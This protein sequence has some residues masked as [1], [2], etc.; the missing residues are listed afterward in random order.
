MDERQQY[1]LGELIMKSLSGTADES[2]FAQMRQCLTNDPEAL[3][4]YFEYVG[5]YAYLESPGNVSFPQPEVSFDLQTWQLLSEY[6]KT[7]PPAEIVPEKPR[8]KEPVKM[9]KVEKPPRTIHKFSLYS[10]II[11]TAA[12]FFAIM[13]VQLAPVKTTPLVGKLTRTVAAQWQDASGHITQGCDLYAGPMS[14][15]AGFA[16]IT[17]DSGAIIVVQA[18]S[19]FTLESAQQVY[20]RQ[21]Q[22]VARKN[23]GGQ[24]AFLVRTPHACIVDYGTEFG[25]KVDSSEQTETYVYEGQVQLR[26]SADPIKFT[27]SLTLTPGQGAMADSQSRLYTKTV[28]P[29]AFVRLVEM[30]I[31]Y[32]AQKDT[33]YYRWRA[34]V[35]QLHR[36]PSLV[37]HYFF[38]KSPTDSDRLVNA[39]FPERRS[40]QG[41]FGDE[42]KGT[43]TWVQ[44]RW[45]QKQAVRFERAREQAIVIPP[46]A[47]LSMTFPLTIST[48]VYFPHKEVWG[49]HLISCREDQ[50]INYQFSLFD[51]N[52]AY[53]Y[54]QN[55]FEF[56][57]YEVLEKEGVGLYSKPFV[58]EIAV[59]YHLAAV[60]DGT[61]IRFYINGTLFESTPYKPLTESEPAEIVIG[62][63]KKGGR[64]AFEEGDFD[65]VVDELMLF[66]RDLSEQEIRA[67][68]EAGKP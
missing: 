14:L 53:G 23:G 15:I 46:H 12:L 42:N 22:I 4:Y 68:Y 29:R 35:Y 1:N 58:P 43:P 17:L 2:D 57:Q 66:N 18:P 10:A 11:S 39:V 38:E 62:A 47:G 6:E 21:G 40:M 31:R 25:V 28:E 33:G 64:Y 45:P 8:L 63:V 3:D 52:Y 9:L 65:G 13:Y 44:G 7:A 56:R 36:D 49:G 60:Y 67:I 26:D 16:E 61:E 20:L 34:S 41:T 24:Q 50:R 55:R 32:R 5:L 19:Q 30:D 54:Q 27:Q 37:A 48:W 51:K 59:W